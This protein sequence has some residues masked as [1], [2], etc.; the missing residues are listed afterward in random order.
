MN[1]NS[2]H[3][4][5]HI[6]VQ[7]DPTSH[8]RYLYH[9]SDIHI[10]NSSRHSEYVTVFNRLYDMLTQ[11]K[12]KWT[13]GESGLIV[14]T[15]DI[16]HSKSQILP[17]LIIMLRDFLTNLS[18]IMP[19]IMIAGNHDLNLSNLDVPD[20]LSSILHK[21]HIQNLHYLK[22]SGVYLWNNIRFG[23]MSVIDYPPSRAEKFGGVS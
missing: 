22:N 18:N 16:V 5:P 8:V 15:G 13:S 6:I 1:L 3:L 7:Q 12:S 2:R 9:V 11:E 20:T 23:V 14:L 19:V 21:T 10:R 17:Q 4:K